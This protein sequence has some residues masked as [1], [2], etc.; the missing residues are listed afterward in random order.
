MSLRD[1]LLGTGPEVPPY[2]LV[3]PPG[4]VEHAPD[5]AGEQA[6]L[7]RASDRLRHQHRP[8]LNAQLRTLARQ[9]FADLR[10]LDA[11]AYFVQESAPEDAIM[12]MSITATRMTAPD[13]G[14]LDA[15]VS[16]LIRSHGARALNDDRAMIRWVRSGTNELNGERIG[17]HTVSYL[18]P[19]PGTRRR[20]ALRFAAV[21][22]HP[23]GMAATE[24]PLAGFIHT[25]DAI[26]GTF[27]WIPR[28]EAT[29]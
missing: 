2:Q 27:A 4:W 10:R 7:A 16:E 6:M 19:I 5:A 25:A 17:A 11:V 12:P 23:V 26:M 3:L 20:S 8:D 14:T 18:T 29:A 22:A 9:A 28:R 1:E 13:G 15:Q 21:I 24:H